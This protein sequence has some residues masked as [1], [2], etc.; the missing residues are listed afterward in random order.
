MLNEMALRPGIAW[1]GGD[2]T[3]KSSM[4]SPAGEPS[5]DDPRSILRFVMSA[6]PER[7]M[8]Y[9]TER[10]YYYKFTLGGR[11]V[12]GNIRFADAEDG[13]FSVGYFDAYNQSDMQVG[14]FTHGEDGV[15]ARYDAQTGEVA[16]GLDG[17]SR[18]FVLD[19]S[20]L[21]P[22]GFPLLSGEQHVTAVRD[23]SGYF[24]QLL[25]YAPG[26]SLYYVLDDRHPRPEGW[27]R[28]ESQQVE[29]WFGERSRFCFVKHPATGRFILVGVNRREISQNTWYDGPFDQVPPR[30][31]LREML[32]EAYPYVQDAGGLDE[33]GNFLKVEG[34][35]VAISPYR[36]YES[37]TELEKD[38]E[39]V[40]LDVGD[41]TAWTAATY[42]Y[43]R[44][45]RAP[46]GDAVA[47]VHVRDLSLGWPANH[48]G[49]SSRGWGPEHA[50]ETSRG[51][52]VNHD[53][54]VSRAAAAPT[55][56]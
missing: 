41:P 36:A 35:R 42:E 10:Y 28:G 46:A 50:A 14:H 32:E 3:L 11:V 22:P 38:L 7:A 34:Q 53:A 8:V 27:V 21:E 31:P 33:H 2:S 55:Q 49:G 54:Q 13:A 18:V 20:A 16:L 43:K 6:A 40:I 23:E 47:G 9:P 52:P 45:W 48:W 25:Y 4:S 39:A 51:W 44:D 26:R 17:L 29:A 1:D 30:L 37:G 24:L 5:F 15:S 56:R 12:S 19:R